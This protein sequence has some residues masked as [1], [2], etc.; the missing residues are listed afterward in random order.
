M[1]SNLIKDMNEVEFLHRIN[2]ANG[3]TDFL[4]TLGMSVRG[5]NWSLVKERIKLSNINTSHFF[6]KSEMSKKT[7]TLSKEEF[8]NVMLQDSSTKRS[9]KVIKKY[10]FLYDFKKEACEKC[11]IGS[12]WCGEPITLQL[13][14]ING[15]NTDDRLENLRILCPNCHSQTE[16]FAGKALRVKPKKFCKDCNVFLEHQGERCRDCEHKRPR[17]LTKLKLSLDEL[18]K[19]VWE[20]PSEII[21]KEQGVSGASISKLCK[22]HNIP[23]PPRGYWAKRIKNMPLTR[24][25]QVAMMP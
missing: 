24:I 9:G 6:S 17:K 1:K 12:W 22:Q 15:V 4:R 20:K 23:K 2:D 21:A 11:G 14:H 10:L 7:T 3:I 16:T 18:A 5:T 19:L 8:V 13:D 25:E